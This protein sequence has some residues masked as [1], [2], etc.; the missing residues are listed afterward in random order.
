MKG[1]EEQNQQICTVSD[2]FV[3]SGECMDMLKQF[4]EKIVTDIQAI[5]TFTQKLN[6][7]SES[8][9]KLTESV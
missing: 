1:I 2:S 3:K 7:V 5:D 8:L 9:N 4:V 6:N